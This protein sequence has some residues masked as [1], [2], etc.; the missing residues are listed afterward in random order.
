MNQKELLIV[1]FFFFPRFSYTEMG[2]CYL[3]FLLNDISEKHFKSCKFHPFEEVMFLRKYVN[4]MVIFRIWLFSVCS[5]PGKQSVVVQV[6]VWF[7]KQYHIQ[8]VLSF[9]C[10][11]FQI[12]MLHHGLYK[13]LRLQD[14]S[15]AHQDFC[16]NKIV[17]I[18]VRIAKCYKVH[19]EKLN[20]FY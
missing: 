4:C 2:L 18:W 3:C 17:G 11:C 16:M 13:Y 19:R 10:A 14:F 15:W 20:Y 12:L 6:K 1:F 5:V 8:L 7:Y 9:L